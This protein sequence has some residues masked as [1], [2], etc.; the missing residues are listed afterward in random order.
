[1]VKKVKIAKEDMEQISGGKVE[2]IK[3]FANSASDSIDAYKV[4]DDK[5]NCTVAIFEDKTRAE[6]FNEKYEHGK[7]SSRSE[8]KIMDSFIAN[9]IKHGKL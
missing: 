6:A 2:K 9:C 8:R 7:K 1:M 5:L 3:V 4:V